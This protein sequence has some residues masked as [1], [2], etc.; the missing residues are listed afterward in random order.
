MMS[1]GY[2]VCCSIQSSCY[3]LY[4]T[5]FYHTAKSLCIYSS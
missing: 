5:N 4:L 2:I 3:T 1:T